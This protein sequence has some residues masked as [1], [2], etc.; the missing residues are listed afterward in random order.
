MRCVCFW[1]C[2]ELFCEEVECSREARTRVWRAKAGVDDREALLPV[3]DVVC[4]REVVRCR[5]C[6]V[7]DVSRSSPELCVEAVSGE[8]G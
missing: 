5:Q 4:W 6:E 1:L 7:A 3:Q 8:K 2:H